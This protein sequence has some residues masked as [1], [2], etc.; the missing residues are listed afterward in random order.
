MGEIAD[1]IMPASK[2]TDEIVAVAIPAKAAADKKFEEYK[3]LLPEDL[4]DLGAK[5]PPDYIMPPYRATNRLT[6][7]PDETSP[8]QAQFEQSMLPLGRDSENVR[9]DWH[10]EEDSDNWEDYHDPDD[11]GRKK[12]RRMFRS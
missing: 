11:D 9:G 2:L 7:Y 4:A 8:E 1:I 5:M 12:L 10:D 3:A 6:Q